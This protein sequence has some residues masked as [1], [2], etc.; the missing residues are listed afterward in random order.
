[1]STKYCRNA[2][3]ANAGDSEASC[4]YSPKCLFKD[5]CFLMKAKQI[6]CLWSMQ[7]RERY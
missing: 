3:Q 7:W 5:K 4:V 2:L 6:K 1:M